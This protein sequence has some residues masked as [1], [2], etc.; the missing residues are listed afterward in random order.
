MK[1][2]LYPIMFSIFNRQFNDNPRIRLYN[3]PDSRAPDDRP[4]TLI[5][6]LEEEGIDCANYRILIDGM[7]VD[8]ADM[9]NS[10]WKQVHA[11]ECVI[12]LQRKDVPGPANIND[13]IAA[14]MQKADRYRQMTLDSRPSRTATSDEK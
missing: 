9:E 2:L 3:M 13:R 10:L 4:K 11:D 14:L 7:P 12:S 6:L 5:E 1:K 8:E